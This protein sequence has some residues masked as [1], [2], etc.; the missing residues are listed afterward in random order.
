[1]VILIKV[2]IIKDGCIID[3]FSIHEDLDTIIKIL[4]ERY[5]SCRLELS[6]SSIQVY[7]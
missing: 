3:K 4:S 1:M 2:E 6:M 5:K 7:V